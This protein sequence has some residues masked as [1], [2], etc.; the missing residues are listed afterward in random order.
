M[1]APP[2]PSSFRRR[3][4]RLLDQ[5]LWCLGKDIQ[6]PKGNVLLELGMCQHREPGQP[7]NGCT[8]YTGPID[9]DCTLWLWG[10]GVLLTRPKTP[11]VFIKRYDFQPKL[12]AALARP[13]HDLN[14]LGSLQRVMNRRDVQL[15]REMLPVLCQWFARYEHWLAETVGHKYRQEVL[16]ARLAKHQA[17]ELTHGPAAA[18]E[19]LAKSCQRYRE[20]P[21]LATPWAKVLRQCQPVVTARVIDRPSTRV[22]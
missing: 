10:F 22:R 20:L 15:L 12:C 21:A 13:I 19:K 17:A 4:A 9:T 16:A 11:A 6:H 1:L 2:T 3:A 5:Q 8:C 18:W 7:V 14:S